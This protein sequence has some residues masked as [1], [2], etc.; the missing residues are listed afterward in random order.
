MSFHM[1]IVSIGQKKAV[2]PMMLFIERTQIVLQGKCIQNKSTRYKHSGLAQRN[3]QQLWF[4]LCSL[5]LNNGPLHVTSSCYTTPLPLN[6]VRYIKPKL[7][8]P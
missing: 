2:K 6:K 3:A 1:P 4:R 5:I 8:M 7:M